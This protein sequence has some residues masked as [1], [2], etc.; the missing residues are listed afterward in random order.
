MAW[1]PHSVVVVRRKKNASAQNN[2]ADGRAL[3]A[4]QGP[5]VRRKAH[6]QHDNAGYT[7]Q[8][9]AQLPLKPAPM[10]HAVHV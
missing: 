9:L 4:E 3:H 8:I 5:H 6:A 7:E 2:H 10:E 1:P